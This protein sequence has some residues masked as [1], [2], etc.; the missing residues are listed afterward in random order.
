VFDEEALFFP[1]PQVHHQ[2]GEGCE[3]A[4][5]RIRNEQRTARD[6][7]VEPELYGMT[8]DRERAALHKPVV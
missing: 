3:Q 4:G 6:E 8:H 7:E 5:C 2:R 1:R